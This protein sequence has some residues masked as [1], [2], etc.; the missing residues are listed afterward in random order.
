MMELH[1]SGKFP[2][3]KFLTVYDIKDFEQAKAD[4]KDGKV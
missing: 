1:R 2:L 3:E 4:V